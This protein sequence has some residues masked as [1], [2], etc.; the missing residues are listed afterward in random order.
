M[1]RR[2]ELGLFFAVAQAFRH[3]HPGMSEREVPQVS[4]W[5]K[6]NKLKAL[7]RLEI[8]DERL[9]KSP[10][11]A[12]DRYSVADITALVAVDFMVPARID[13]P[14]TLSGISRWYAEVSA[15]PSARA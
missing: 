13:R 15:R 11:I 10:F 3:L 8:L 9:R 1:E 2:V 12:G 14:E 6:A 5:G 4:E 7:E